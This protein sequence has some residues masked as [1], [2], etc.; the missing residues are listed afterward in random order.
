MD[1]GIWQVVL[2]SAPIN[3]PLRLLPAMDHASC[4]VIVVNFNAGPVLTE[5]IEA[6]LDST[7]PA[8]ILLVDNASTDTSLER[9]L[10]RWSGEPR[11]QVVRN[12]QNLGFS[13]AC[14]KGLDRVKGRWILFLNPDCIV[15]RDTLARMLLAVEGRADVGMAGCLIRNLDGT[16]QAGC[17]RREPTP[18]RS[19]SR[20]L[21]LGSVG[22]VSVGGGG[23]NMRREPLPSEPITVDAISGAFMLVRREAVERVG[24]LDEGYF[25]HCEDLDWCR[26]FRDA[27][28]RILFVPDVEVIH[29]KGTGS[30][31][32]PVWVEW[33]K[34][35]GM[36]RYFRKF[37]RHRHSIWMD[38]L[39]RVGVWGRFG[40]LAAVMTIRRLRK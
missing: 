33:Q 21:R 14:N 13:A 18:I 25:L 12:L 11:L 26:R 20:V 10:A 36:L 9:V 23:L 8:Q 37:H 34:H 7:V 28:F 3:D 24:P 27:G 4:S 19:L 15:E 5:C 39:V 17:R 32:R 6:L 31:G 22:L 29:H 40:A 1:A 38:L 35:R 30:R 16:E 2:D